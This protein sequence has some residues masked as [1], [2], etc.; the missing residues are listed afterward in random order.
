MIFKY[1]HPLLLLLPIF[2]SAINGYSV[3][4]AKGKI[5]QRSYHYEKLDNGLQV[6]LISDPQADKAAASLDVPV[7]SS[8]DPSGREGL[9]H[10]L[11]HM[12][13]LGTEKYPQADE[14]QTF[15][16]N[17]GGSHN[18]Y[19]SSNHTNYFFDVNAADLA[20]A[21]DRFAQF[22][23][24]PL[25]D[26]NYVER[27]RHAVDSEFKAKYKDD[28]RRT[29]DVYQQLVNPNH[30]AAKFS[31]GSLVTLA[32]RPQNPVRDDLL[33]FYRHHYSAEKMALVVLGRESMTELQQLIYPLFSQIPHQ[34]EGGGGN[35]NKLS[36]NSGNIE[37]PLFLPNTLPLEAVIKP[38]RILR[39]M[40][41]L[42]PLP[43][44]KSYYRQK[45]LDYI[46]NIIGHEGEGSL[47]SLLK[48]QGWAEALSAGI[49]SNNE[50]YSTFQ[51]TVRLSENGV[52]H[53]EQIRQ[54]IF[55]V[56]KT[57]RNHGI[58]IWRY[59]ESK[60]LADIAFQYQ[61][62]GRSIDTVRLL[63]NNLHD[64]PAAD[65]IRGDYAYDNFDALLIDD[66]LS[67]MTPENVLVLSTFPEAETDR[68]S[69]NYQ[70]PYAVNTLSVA[71]SSIKTALPEELVKQFALPKQNEFIPQ[72]A[73]LLTSDQLINAPTPILLQDK[74][75]QAIWF[76]QDTSFNVPRANLVIRIK[77][78]LVS[79]SIDAASK[80]HLYAELVKDQL[81]EKSYPAS[82]AGLSFSLSANSRGIDI[83]LQGYDD[84]MGVLLE[85]LL[86]TITNPVF[87]DNRFVNVKQELIKNWNNSKKQTPYRRLF[88][89]LPTI[90]FEPYWS[91][92]EMAEAIHGVTAP[93]MRQF[94][95][96]WR[97]G[98]ELQALLYGNIAQ[99]AADSWSRQLGNL[100][101]TGDKPVN[102]A[103]VVKLNNRDAIPGQAITVNHNDKAVV[104]Y[105]QGE[106]DTLQDNANMLLL[107]QVVESA[108]YHELRTEQQLGYI[109]FVTAMGL[110][111]VPGSL[112]VVQS[113][114]ASVPHI[115]Q[116][117][118]NFLVAYSEQLPTDLNRHKQAVLTHL[119][120]RPKT[121]SEMA[122]RQ[123]TNILKNDHTFSY[124]KRLA[125][126]VSRLEFSDLQQ[127]YRKVILQPTKSYWLYTVTAK[128]EPK[129]QAELQVLPQ[130]PKLQAE[131]YYQYP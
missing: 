20:P 77:S 73:E 112:F 91:Q 5:D 10:F 99:S 127:Y 45:P 67:A 98:A 70:T 18:A 97:N 43:P 94:S 6:L 104:L 2:L 41:L 72:S 89:E 115:Q 122:E 79:Q 22:F 9:A 55:Y 85:L 66:Y 110:K 57:L 65:V 121:L 93:D 88:D 4:I 49:Y 90:L 36:G 106:T 81:A 48:K 34:K 78:P 95:G 118:Q 59:S 39:E 108:F 16:S 119:L 44:V 38:E 76:K 102:A 129:N 60:Q 56:L 28:Y 35:D 86:K 23:I 61:E 123:W 11:E 116:S 130:L 125:D 3:E 1:L 19:T 58:E 32:D 87:N 15:I 12:L 42:F 50:D 21:L 126:H 100:I 37:T 74:E 105:V 27:E 64:Y 71:H 17:H 111:E 68:I 103:R 83:T 114:Q 53:R 109:V 13:F 96:E 128:Q 107:Q 33:N 40:T 63:A 120:E 8:D 52:K 25:F 117:I 80:M 14:Y 124:R 131:S 46:G 54:L 113:P 7:G 26:A 24:A 92:L 84:R 29:Y 101:E 82:L 62:A 75:R 69:S 47:L 31:V 51:I 30:P